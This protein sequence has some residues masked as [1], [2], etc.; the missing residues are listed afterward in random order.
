MKKKLTGLYGFIFL[1]FALPYANAQKIEKRNYPQQY[2]QWPV[3]AVK[4]LAANFGELRPNHYHMGLDCKTD[5]MENKPIYAAASGYIA[6]VK[7][8]PW[9]F[10]RAIYI[11]HPNGLTT[12]YAHLNDF[13][14]ALEQY[15]KAQQYRLQKW[16]IFIDIPAGL[17]PVIKGNFIAFSGNSGG[18]QGPH[19]H[20]EVR[21]T[22]TEKVLNPLLMGFPIADNVAP[23]ILRLAVYDRCKSTYEQTPKIYPLKKVNGVYMPASGNLTVN[24]EKVSFAI[25]AYDTYNGSSNQ[26][27]IYE[28]QLYDNEKAIAGFQIDSI[29]YLET[30]Y[31]NAHIDY[32]FKANG[33]SY[34]QHLSKLPGNYDAVYKT[35][36]SNGVISLDT[37]ND[38][39][40]KISVSDPNGNTSL[41]RFKISMSAPSSIRPALPAMARKQFNPGFINVFENDRIRF[42]LP[43]KALYDSF[44][45][46]YNE[47][48]DI[49][50]QPIYQLHDATVPL[51]TYFTLFIKQNFLMADTGKIVM[52]RF[53]NNKKDY[54]KA[55]FD[56]GWY[57]AAFREF[58]NFLLM[59]DSIPPSVTSIGLVNGMNASKLNRLLFVVKDNTE[60]IK[61]F[62]ALLDGKWLRFSNDKGK[63]FIYRFDENCLPG[64]HELVITAEDQVG[65]I[66][67][68]IY[69]FTR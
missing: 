60:E 15:V 59:V 38:H 34:L 54:S 28:A 27:G 65:N 26:N 69:Q 4:A 12:L 9:G 41:V 24:T 8:E 14:P 2:F 63:N 7:I 43:E 57:K 3:G 10:G 1:V 25:T 32:K 18:S 62:T 30:R 68:K 44:N 20:F 50:S 39:S 37:L 33:G 53:Y 13:Y 22:Q 5:K 66:T 55:S 56:N 23:Q 31:M 29:S 21:D 67:K 19:L 51:H 42:Y 40:I 35:D 6:K 61:N 64:P 46:R 47:M 36:E 48:K 45:F 49:N 58:G 17:F 11:N 16:N 52:H